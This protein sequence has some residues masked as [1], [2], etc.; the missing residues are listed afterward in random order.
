MIALAAA[1]TADAEA[2]EDKQHDDLLAVKEQQA[3]GGGGGGGGEDGG[4]GDE[5][6]ADWAI[7]LGTLV[8]TVE[9]QQFVD[10]QM[11]IFKMAEDGR[12]ECN[13]LSPREQKTKV[14]EALVVA[15]SGVEQVEDYLKHALKRGPL[16]KAMKEGGSQVKKVRRTYFGSIELRAPFFVR[17]VSRLF[18]CPLPASLGFHVCMLHV[19][20][21]KR[22]K[23]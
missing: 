16:M 8:K 20:C 14:N 19:C 13:Q 17:A 21:W 9:L 4:G 1:V 5:G 11:A 18:V 12:R 3:T 7:Y 6:P 22:D 23:G 10:E 15:H 2:R